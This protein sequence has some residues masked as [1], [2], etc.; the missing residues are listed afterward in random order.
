MNSL[1]LAAWTWK[2]PRR[3]RGF[4]FSLVIDL[5]WPFVVLFVRLRVRG[6]HHVPGDGGVILAFNHLSNA[7]SVAAVVFALM[8]NRVPR[9]LAKAALW[10][11]PVFG[12]AMRSGG[13]IPVERGTV[14]ASEALR[15]AV[16]ALRAGEC[17][18]VFPEGTFTDD[19]GNWPMKGKSGVARMALESRV[20]VVPV[21]EWGTQDLLP[22][23]AVL[24]RLLPRK[25]VEVVAGAPVDLSDLYDLEMTA[26]VLEE[27]TSRVMDAITTM[28]SGIRSARTG[29][30]RA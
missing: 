21:A 3:G 8:S 30:Q 27:A 25:R 6:R 5:L 16:E 18:M 22:R 1:Q 23:G 19:P 2:M 10:R 11:T 7:D 12:W 9:V 24:P 13:H 15:P 17:V 28:L 26:E 29:S 14:K 20:P 4:W